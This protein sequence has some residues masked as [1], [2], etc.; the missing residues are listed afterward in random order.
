MSDNKSDNR[1]KKDERPFKRDS[2]HSWDLGY[3]IPRADAR[4]ERR[5]NK[6]VP[7]EKAKGTRKE[8]PLEP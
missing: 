5:E 6:P 8:R 1:P 7:D 4:A 3:G 2:D